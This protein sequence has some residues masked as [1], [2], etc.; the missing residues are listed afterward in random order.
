[1]ENVNNLPP[2]LSSSHSSSVQ[3]KPIEA[4]AKQTS[5]L[6]EMS[7]SEKAAPTNLGQKVDV[8]V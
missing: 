3:T 5:K 7:E 4:A 8:K 6:M 1:M 2:Q